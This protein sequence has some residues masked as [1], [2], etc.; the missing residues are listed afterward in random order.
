MSDRIVP[1]SDRTVHWTATVESGSFA[2]SAVTV[3]PFMPVVA[4][5]A[6]YGRPTP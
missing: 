1:T 2:A 4:P 3:V 6:A 5:A